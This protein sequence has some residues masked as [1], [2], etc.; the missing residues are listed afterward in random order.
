MDE[1][2]KSIKEASDPNAKKYSTRELMEEWKQEL[3][4]T[5]KKGKDRICCWLRNFTDYANKTDEELLS[6]EIL[7]LSRLPVKLNSLPNEIHYLQNLR[8]LDISGH[9]LRYIPK[10]I[11]AMFKLQ[12]LKLSN[13]RITKLPHTIGDI[14]NLKTFYIDN[15]PLKN[16]TPTL[17]KLQELRVLDISNCRFQERPEVLEF[18]EDRL[19]EIIL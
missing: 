5:E 19:E 13:N 14:K 11:G 6:L 12:S 10:G 18:I 1:L 7:D 2:D 8:F 17:I 4:K 9:K 16:L 15:N 3:E